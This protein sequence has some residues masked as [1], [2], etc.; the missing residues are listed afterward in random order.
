MYHFNDPSGYQPNPAFQPQ[1]QYPSRA[2]GI[3]PSVFYTAIKGNYKNGDFSTFLNY[4]HLPNL[5]DSIKNGVPNDEVPFVLY[6]IILKSLAENNFT[7][8]D[9]I[10]NTIDNDFIKR[11]IVDICRDIKGQSYHLLN[12]REIDILSRIENHALQQLPSV[13]PL[14]QLPN[15]QLSEETIEIVPQR[16]PENMMESMQTDNPRG[17]RKI[18]KLRE[19]HNDFI[20]E[21]FSDEKDIYNLKTFF[22]NTYYTKYEKKLISDYKEQVVSYEKALRDSEIALVREDGQAEIQQ[23]SGFFRKIGKWWNMKREIVKK[24]KECRARLTQR[25]LFEL[26]EYKAQ[27]VNDRMSVVTDSQNIPEIRIDEQQQGLSFVAKQVGRDILKQI[28][29]LLEKEVSKTILN[30]NTM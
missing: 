19:E 13:T 14:A 1:M 22:G 5:L 10:F 24:K 30:T 18:L 29:L 28:N 21:K 16:S 20:A 17:F 4:S 2:L 9:D 3:T 11:E 7:A 6:A 15:P 8:I 23:T 12:L 26:P 25:F 27:L